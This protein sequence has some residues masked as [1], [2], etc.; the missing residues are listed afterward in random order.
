MAVGGGWSAVT[1]VLQQL[2]AVTA[3]GA[4]DPLGELWSQLECSVSVRQHEGCRVVSLCL[5]RGMAGEA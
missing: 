4:P 1:P 5:L 2:H 3:A